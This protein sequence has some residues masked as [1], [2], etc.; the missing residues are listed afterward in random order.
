MNHN[1]NNDTVGFFIIGAAVGLL[2]LFRP[3]RYAALLLIAVLGGMYLWDVFV[4]E[5][6]M[7]PADYEFSI[8]STNPQ[9][10]ATWMEHNPI[11]KVEGSFHNTSNIFIQSMMLHSVLYDCPAADS[12]LD[13]CDKI[14]TTSQLVTLNAGP[15][16]RK[17]FDE[18]VHFPNAENQNRNLVVVSMAKDVVGDTDR[19]ED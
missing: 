14:S 16:M 8:T 3:A 5:K 2:F 7:K 15:G 6:Y 1:D 17:G 9:T 13:V 4:T 10:D 18:M 11:F 19:Q 12:D